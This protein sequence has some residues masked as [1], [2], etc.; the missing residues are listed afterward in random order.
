MVCKRASLPVLFFILSLVV[1]LVALWL[2]SNPAAAR[3]L[4]ADRYVAP[5]GQDLGNTCLDSGHPCRT[6]QAAVDAAEEGDRILVAAGLYT[7]VYTRSIPPGYVAPPGF[8]Q[9]VQVAIITKSLSVL[10]GYTPAFDEPPDP[11]ANPTTLDAGGQGRVVALGGPIS[12]TLEGLRLVHGDATGLYGEGGPVDAGGGVYA[13]GASLAVHE[14]VL[15]ESN[16]YYGG[17]LYSTLGTVTVQGSTF[18]SNTAY[19][20]GGLRLLYSDGVL[21][22]NT[23]EHNMADAA[24]GAALTNCEQATFDGNTVVSNTATTSAGGGVY[25]YACDAL[26]SDNEIAWNQG[27]KGGGLYVQAAS[28]AVLQTNTVQGNIADWGGGAEYRIYLPMLVKNYLPSR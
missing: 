26:V 9:T 11:V 25:L 5:D 28:G 14:C 23:L 22:G 21:T 8:T 3:T 2:A 16:A 17:G 4:A 7:G 1:A 10:G 20:G 13:T 27:P 6:I 12:V 24:G 18:S 19:Y 15:T